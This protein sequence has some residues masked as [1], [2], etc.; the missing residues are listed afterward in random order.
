MTIPKMGAYQFGVGTGMNGNGA[1]RYNATVA[2]E[3]R[4]GR[5]IP[6]ASNEAP[7]VFKN[8]H[9]AFTWRPLSCRVAFEEVLPF[10]SLIRFSFVSL[11]LCHCSRTVTWWNGATADMDR[12]SIICCP[13]SSIYQDDGKIVLVLYSFNMLIKI[14]Y[15][16]FQGDRFGKVTCI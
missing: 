3:A 15:R 8:A 14:H 6:V 4:I 7:Q 10:L 5:P 16:T 9:D 13:C 2:A 1:E 11:L 12:S